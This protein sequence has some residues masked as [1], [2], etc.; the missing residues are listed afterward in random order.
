MLGWYLEQLWTLLLIIV[1]LFMIYLVVRT[2]YRTT[3]Q[4]MEFYKNK[5]TIKGKKK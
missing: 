2:I 5:K 1:V 3:K 4:D